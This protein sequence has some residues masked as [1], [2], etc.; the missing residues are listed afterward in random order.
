MLLKQ[1]RKETWRKGKK[2]GKEGGWGEKKEG[3]EEWREDR[4]DGKRRWGSREKEKVMD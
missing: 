2:R 1:G 4:E 3:I